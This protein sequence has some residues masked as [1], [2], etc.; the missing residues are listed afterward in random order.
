MTRE[1]E[2]LPL[3]SIAAGVVFGTTDNPP[4]GPLGGGFEPIAKASKVA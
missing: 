4:A 3:H 1:R 2:P